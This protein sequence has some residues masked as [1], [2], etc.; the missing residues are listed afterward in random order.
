MGLS[1]SIDRNMSRA[2]GMSMRDAHTDEVSNFKDEEIAMNRP[3]CEKEIKVLKHI[4]SGAL[5]NAF[6][7]RPRKNEMWIE[8]AS[9]DRT[10]IVF[11]VGE[12]AYS[13]NSFRL[14][15]GS[16]WIGSGSTLTMTK[17]NVK[18]VTL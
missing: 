14:S 9:D 16:V 2:P 1:E 7:Y 8:L 4:A 5:H 10:S 11:H 6:G 15:D 12:K 3:K 17:G 18:G 13:F